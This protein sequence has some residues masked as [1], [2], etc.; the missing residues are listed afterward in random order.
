MVSKL[1]PLDPSSRNGWAFRVSGFAFQIPTTVMK[2]KALPVAILSQRLSVL[3]SWNNMKSF[4]VFEMKA[5]ELLQLRVGGFVAGPVIQANRRM[6]GRTTIAV[7]RATTAAFYFA[8]S[9]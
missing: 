6:T 7:R 2:H 8:K 3:D 9:R 5:Y 1:T 4:L